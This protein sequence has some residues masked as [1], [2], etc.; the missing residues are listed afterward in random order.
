MNKEFIPYEQALDLESIGFDIRP[1]FGNQTSLYTKDGRH[2]FYTNYGVMG[3]GLYDGYNYSNTEGF[4][5]DMAKL[6]LADN[7]FY[8][9]VMKVY[10][11]VS[12]YPTIQKAKQFAGGGDAGDNYGGQKD[13]IVAELKSMKGGLDNKAPYVFIKDGLIYISAENA[14]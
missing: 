7:Y 2:L 12:K 6:R 13:E 10:D 9:K 4:K 11:E 8:N 14:S 5:K 1:D 3:S